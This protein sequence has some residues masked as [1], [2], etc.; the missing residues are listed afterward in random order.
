MSKKTTQYDKNIGQLISSNNKAYFDYFIEDIYEAGI[1]LQGTEVKS[2]RENKPTLVECHASSDGG[3]IFVYNLHIA[4][5]EHGNQFNHYPR[6]PKKLLLHKK[7]IKKLIGLVQRKGF[8][9]VLLKIYSTARG[10]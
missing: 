2:L 4:E 6:R 5:Y 1:V 3:E 9:L 7:E 8:T 10:T